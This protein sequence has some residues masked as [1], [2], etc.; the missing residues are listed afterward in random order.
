MLAG[1]I[2]VHR[3]SENR[4][5][6]AAGRN[7]NLFRKLCGGSALRNAVL[8]TNMWGVNTR[9]ISEAREKELSGKNFKPALDKGAQMVRH[10]NTTKSA[11]DIIRKVVSNQPV[12]LQIQR[13]LVDERKDIIDT[14]AGESIGRELREHISQY[15]AELKEVQERMAQAQKAKNEVTRRELVEAKRRLEENVKKIRKVSEGVNAN[16]AAEMGRGDLKAR[17]PR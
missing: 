9:G 1:V 6:G 14:A 13:E 7:F 3:V 10:H 11:H 5:G 16:Y 8:V 4:F 15:Q 17:P 2:Y 12:A